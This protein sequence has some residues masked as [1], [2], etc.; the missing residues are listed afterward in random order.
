LEGAFVILN[1]GFEDFLGNE[2][3]LFLI[4]QLISFFAGA[5][6]FNEKNKFSKT[7]TKKI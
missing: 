6:I 3:K 4:F 5:T 2:K 7:K 1:E